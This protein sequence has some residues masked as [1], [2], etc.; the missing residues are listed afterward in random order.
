MARQLCTLW[1]EK[2]ARISIG[3]ATREMRIGR[4]GEDMKK[5]A[6]I[7]AILVLAALSQGAAGAEPARLVTPLAYG[8][9]LPGL[10][11]PAKELARLIKERSGGTLELELKE[12]GDGTQPQEILD[13]VAGGAVDAGFATSSFWAATSSDP[14][15]RSSS[16]S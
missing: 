14:T 13:K 12:P 6:L 2:G 5:Q 15:C 16:P 4:R 1:R 10:G 8:T 7:S 11:T 9:H 3:Y